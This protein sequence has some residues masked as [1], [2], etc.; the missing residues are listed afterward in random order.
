MAKID[1][2]SLDPRIR[3]TRQMLYQALLDLLGEKSFDTISVQ[4]VAERSTVNRATFYDHFSDKFALLDAMM[5]ER[6]SSL[7]AARMTE[8]DGTCRK[9]LEQLILAVCDFLAEAASGCQKHQRQFEP[10]VE[11]KVKSAVRE[12]LLAGLHRSKT[13]EA[14]L[15]ATLVSWAIC[16]AAMQWS[17]DKASPPEK[18]VE[19]ILPIVQAALK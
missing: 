17:R 12:Y 18:L 10:M 6:F 7:C 2:P 19:T 1:T 8:S 16:G 9:G 13:P 4:D 3:R 11:S 15:K 5:G 14:E